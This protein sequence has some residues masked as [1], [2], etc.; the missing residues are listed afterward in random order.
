MKFW[1]KTKLLHEIRWFFRKNLIITFII[2][3]HPIG[4][5]VFSQVIWEPDVRLTNHPDTS[6]TVPQNGWTIGVDTLHHVHVVWFDNRDGNFEIYYKRSTDGGTNWEQDRR[7]TNDPG[8]SVGPSVAVSQKSDV[9]IVWNDIRNGVPRLYYIHSLD[10]GATWDSVRELSNIAQ[11]EQP[12]VAVGRNDDSVHVVWTKLVFGVSEVFYKRS[13]DGG[14]NWGAD[15]RLTF[16]PVQKEHPVCAVDRRGWVH[17]VWQDTRNSTQDKREVY[18][19]RSTDGGATWGQDTR[20]TFDPNGSSDQTVAVGKDGR[21]HVVWHDDRDG[22]FEIYYKRSPDGGT[23][24]EPDTQLTYT[25]TTYYV[26]TDLPSVAVDEL[27][28]I[29]VVW[30]D[31]RSGIN[32]IYYKRQ[33]D[34]LWEPEVQLTNTPS[35]GPSI[36]VEREGTL[37]VVWTDYR[38][39]NYEIYYKRGRQVDISVEESKRT[40]S[41]PTGVRLYQNYPNPF[42]SKTTITYQVP[43]ESRVSLKIYNIAGEIVKIL[44]D[45]YQKAGCYKIKWDGKN[46]VGKILPSGIY[47]IELST[48]EFSQTIKLLILK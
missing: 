20:L 10:G 47:F 13:L 41:L 45:K 39:G 19:K 3:T 23:T 36:T 33:K 37:H 21:V 40:V 42:T 24:W 26:T 22:N 6:S 30:Q 35:F 34:S 1:K 28:R 9:H 8:T 25:D 4:V 27:G 11:W 5:Q 46:N 17:I 15:Q 18:Y 2:L 48:G 38:D 16:V 7:L 14:T 31:K 29:H 43:N 32:S 44:V 12:T